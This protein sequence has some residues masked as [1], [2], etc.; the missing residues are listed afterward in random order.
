MNNS[1]TRAGTCPNRDPR[2]R[3][4]ARSSVQPIGTCVSPSVAERTYSAARGYYAS[5]SVLLVSRNE[6]PNCGM[7][8][9]LPLARIS[10]A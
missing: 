2:G 6:S 10:D 8:E 4:Q 9:G 3:T 7:D 5:T 1:R